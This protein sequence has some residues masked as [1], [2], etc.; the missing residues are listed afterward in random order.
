MRSKNPLTILGPDGRPLAGA[1]V[2]TKM[3][4]SGEAATVYAAETGG[5]AGTNPALSDSHGEV[6]QWL[7]RGAYSS[8]VTAE[9]MEART[10]PWDS[11][12]GGDHGIDH[13]ALA[14]TLQEAAD[15]VPEMEEDVK[16]LETAVAALQGADYASQTGPNNTAFGGA[17]WTP[18]V[19]HPGILTVSLER[20]AGTGGTVEVVV[21]GMAA[22]YAQFGELQQGVT[23][24]VPVP[25]NAK[26]VL[27]KTGLSTAIAW[28]TFR[29]WV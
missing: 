2:S 15:A 5:G 6:E 10:I 25:K 16:D 11:V 19:S 7:E 3:R 9:G 21:G 13:D 20:G 23:V 26:V 27:K 12:P 22:A 8:V 14:V 18:S 4:P 28:T 29:E 1:S 17:G 24:T